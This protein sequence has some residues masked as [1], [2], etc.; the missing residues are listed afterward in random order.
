MDSSDSDSL[1]MIDS[2]IVVSEF[3]AVGQKFVSG[4]ES[5]VPGH[6]PGNPLLPGVL[7]LECLAEVA[8]A[9]VRKCSGHRD[10]AITEV[11][12]LRFVK[13]VTPGDVLSVEVTIAEQQPDG[14]LCTGEITSNGVLKAKGAVF[15]SWCEAT[16]STT[17]E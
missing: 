5:F 10:C 1:N 4:T 6:Y 7:L 13:P 16:G 17:P 14:C 2:E 9:L 15:V 12:Q 8:E 3:R 11:K